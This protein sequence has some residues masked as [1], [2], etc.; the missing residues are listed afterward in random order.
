MTIDFTKLPSV[1]AFKK[2]Y[3]VEEMDRQIER[4]DTC[5]SE[6]FKTNDWPIDQRIECLQFIQTISIVCFE[7]IEA[8]ED[9][10]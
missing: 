6:T 9:P 4:I 7:L 3:S 10:E 8:I 1:A 5:M 2:L